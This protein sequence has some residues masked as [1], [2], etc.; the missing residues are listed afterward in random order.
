MTKLRSFPGCIDLNQHPRDRGEEPHHR[1]ARNLV[2]GSCVFGDGDPARHNRFICALRS[3]N[4]N[5]GRLPSRHRHRSLVFY[6]R[7]IR[8]WNR[9]SGQWVLCRSS[10]KKLINP[11]AIVRTPR[12]IQPRGAVEFVPATIQHTPVPIITR[13]MR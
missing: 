12:E 4:E 3:T 5:S 6:Q 7:Q 2:H 13:E 1:V 9:P 11:T 10:V 8:A